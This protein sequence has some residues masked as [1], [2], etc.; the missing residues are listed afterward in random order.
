MLLARIRD[1]GAGLRIGTGITSATITTSD[2]R[3][4]EIAARFATL[5][6]SMEGFA[7]LRAA[8]AAGVP[9]LEVRGISNIVGDRAT[10]GWDFRAGAAAA[11]S[12]LE[13]VLD[14]VQGEA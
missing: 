8:G 11:A 5:T 7:V 2:A 9:V 3:A 13:T 14:I 12:A 4:A 10:S 6:E 1:R